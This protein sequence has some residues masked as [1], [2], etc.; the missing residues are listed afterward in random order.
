MQSQQSTSIERI[1]FFDHIRYLM[2]LLVVVLHSSCAY[3]RFTNWWWVNDINKEFFDYLLTFLGLF[4]MPILFFIAG[5]FALPSIQPKSP[6]EFMKNKL[7]RLGIPLILGVFLVGPYL[8]YTRTLQSY[9]ATADYWQKFNQNINYSVAFRTGLIRSQDQFQ[10]HYFWFISLLLL[11]FVIFALFQKLGF[12]FVPTS[13]QASKKS[14]LLAFLISGLIA[15]FFALII[16]GMLSKMGIWGE[17]WLTVA[18]LIQFQPTAIAMYIVYFILGIFAYSRNWFKD[19]VVPGHYIFWASLSVV[20]FGVFVKVRDA[21][22]QIVF[23]GS[24]VPAHYRVVYVGIR[25]FIVFTFLLMFV[26]FSVKHWNRSSKL[27]DALSASSYNIYL[28][29]MLF[30][31]TIQ[32]FLNQWILGMAYFKFILVALGSVLL[33]FC[34]SHFSIRPYPKRSI[35]GII[36][37]A[38]ILF[39]IL[40]P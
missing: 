14:I 4:L 30:V 27:N 7:K 13:K 3:S 31:V 34:I 37:L 24:S 26:S 32:S 19:G 8:K 15:S 28:V 33:S 18:N 39:F 29:H 20:L 21:I 5:Y 1:F 36:V 23:S 2:V 12:M 6:L 17:P 16:H 9:A 11:F 22:I 10:H 25:H 35:I 40:R 38:G